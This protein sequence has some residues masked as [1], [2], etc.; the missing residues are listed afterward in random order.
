MEQVVPSNGPTGVECACPSRCAS[1]SEEIRNDPAPSCLYFPITVLF[2]L[3]SN[4]RKPLALVSLAIR[5]LKRVIRT[6]IQPKLISW[7]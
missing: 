2:F 5:Q 6:L 7:V 3:V 1:A 4:T